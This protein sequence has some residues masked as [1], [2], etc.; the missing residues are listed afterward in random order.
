MKIKSLEIYGYGRF[1]QRKI[2]FDESFTEIYGEN[3]TGKSTIQAFIH[4]ILFGFPT[5][6]ENEPRL[7]PRLGN[8]YGGRLTLIQE[9]GSLVDVERIKG[10]AVGDVKVYLPNG[11]IKDETW[12]KKELN[13][14]SKRTYQGIFSFDVLGLQDIHK[15]M[16]ETQLQNYLLQAG[17]L[18]STEFTSMRG[19]LND[20]K[21]MLYKKNGRNPII[22]QQLEQLKDLEGQIR[23][24]EAKLTT[25]KRL[26]DDKDK[27]ERRLD[28]LKQN[29][30]QL[31][32][33]HE[34]KQKELA[35]HEQTQEWKNLESQVNIEPIHF[36][37]QG[38]DRYESAK[39]QT[40]NLKRD[41]GLREEKLA[42]LKSENEK[43]NVPQQRDIDAFNHL[44]QQ[45][46][47]IK[48]K[49]YELKAV[50]KEIQDKER[51]KT[52]L[53][54]NIGWHEVYH[55]ADSS[56]AMKSYVSNQIKNKQEQ[57][58]FVQQLER[59]IEENKIDQ[60]TNASEIEALEADI[61]PEENF[62]KKK[63]YNKQVF[64]LKEK[65]HLYQKM[66][67]VF[68]KN[69]RESEKKQSLL[70][71]SL[72]IL[73]VISIGLTIFSFVST[74][75]LFGVI[76]AILS[77]IFVIGIFFVRTKEIGHSET[78]SKEIDDLQHQV[79]HLEDNYDLDFD[80]E[81]QYKVREQLQ[82]T[83][84]TKESLKKKAEYL[85]TSL[86][87]A[88]TQY[89]EAQD[90]I[91]KIKLDLHL[92][93]KMSDELIIDSIGT[94]NKIKEHDKHIEELNNQARQLNQ[95]L[96]AFYEHA[97]EITKNQFTYFNDL[98]LF[99][100]IRQWLKEETSNL[101]RW[102]RNDE[103]IKLIES[104]VSQLSSRL[105][106]NNN[107][108]NQLFGYV[109][110][111]DEEA[112]YQHHVQYQNY[113]KQIARFNDLSK[114]LE[115]QN[116]NYDLSTK[117][118]D[119]TSAQLA[120]EDEVLSRQV[121][122]YNDQYLVMQS[123]VSDLN[124]KITDMETDKTLADLRH[125]FHIL[126][127]KVNDEAKD[128]A[129]LSYLQTLVE[130]HIKQIKDK[131]LPEVINE[132][133]DIFTHL[134]N[135]HYVQVTYANDELMVKQRNGQ[136]YEPVELSQSTKEILYIS[137]RLSLI[138]TL[139]TYYPFPIIIDDAFVHFDKQRKEIMM[140]YL[141]QMPKDYQILFFTCM[142]DTSVPS[143]QIITL[144]KFEEG[145]K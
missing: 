137:L 39:I 69:Q 40:Q 104:E 11:T 17:A 21:E 81:D 130:G 84:K 107:V 134:T 32:K 123:E 111:I 115:N 44:H 3:E 51:E 73:A 61:V 15:N 94:M 93:D 109:N 122:D 25:Y 1:I 70:R 35:L 102:K 143:K 52:G 60:N 86:G 18:G 96:T 12:L 99:H 67:E 140:N 112:Y 119:K 85:E 89:Q 105:D 2:E 29:L 82:N 53:K 62:E 31:S 45:E 141:R 126:K 8:Q 75:I 20:K 19:I 14:I 131:R 106:E 23:E 43:I 138:K 34:Q 6:K 139:K 120:N 77:V 63:Q 10:S 136:M 127:N 24:E 64:E 26:V 7:E 145:G 33:M 68:D 22:N 144:N 66:K 16:D 41:L 49:E 46:N 108:I 38:I 80:L 48:Q 65:N 9:D 135:S 36:P 110:A 83:V 92:S 56:E 118:S 78:F 133:T 42:H 128:W 57:T 74:N 114:Y 47:E 98:S 87:Q 27:S 54:S 58:A 79:T 72:I 71:I 28:N 101:E 129:S 59:S 124:A 113:H 103:Q 91:D 142:K 125:R 55:H 121:D 13:F 116:Y 90:S 4:S 100:D 88:R 30:A 95:E 5:K 50:E 76:F 132:A 97:K 117:L 37:E